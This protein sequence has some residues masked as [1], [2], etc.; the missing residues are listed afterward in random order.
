[1]LPVGHDAMAAERKRARERRGDWGTWAW[2]FFPSLVGFER[3]GRTRAGQD[4]APLLDGAFRRGT[5]LYSGYYGRWQRCFAVL[6]GRTVLPPQ[7]IGPPVFVW[8]CAPLTEDCLM[9]HVAEWHTRTWQV[10]C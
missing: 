8:L 2:Q 4:S 9:P 10:L 3:L 5:V 6:C 1:M 7:V